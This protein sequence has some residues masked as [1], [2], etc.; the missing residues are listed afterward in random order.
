M[1]LLET[2]Q[3][4]KNKQTLY[5]NKVTMFLSFLGQNIKTVTKDFA[6]QRQRSLNSMIVNIRCPK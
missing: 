4:I 3:K 5:L 6:L 2:K 1:N